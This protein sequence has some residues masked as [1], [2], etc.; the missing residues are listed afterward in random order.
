M[1]EVAVEESFVFV[2]YDESI[3]QAERAALGYF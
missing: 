2:Y 3:S 1:L